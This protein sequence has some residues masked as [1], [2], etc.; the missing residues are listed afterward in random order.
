MDYITSLITSA[1]QSEFQKA[2]I[3][4]AKVLAAVVAKARKK[5]TP[6]IDILL[7][8]LPAEIEKINRE[9]TKTAQEQI[10]LA[11]SNCV[12][13][14]FTSDAA[15]PLIGWSDHA[16]IPDARLKSDSMMW[17]YWHKANSRQSPL[18]EATEFFDVLSERA[19]KLQT[20]LP[21]FVESLSKFTSLV[22]WGLPENAPQPKLI[23]KPIV[24]MSKE[25]VLDLI[26]ITKTMKSSGFNPEGQEQALQN[27]DTAA[28]KSGLTVD[29]VKHLA[30]SY[31]NLKDTIR[32]S[33]R[34]FAHEFEL[35]TG[36][37]ALHHGIFIGDEIVGSD[38]FVEVQNL[39]LDKKVCGIVTPSTLLNFLFRT[40]NNEK[41]GLIEFSYNNPLP[42][43]IVQE[44]ALACLGKWPYHLLYNNCEHFVT[45][46]L[47]NKASSETCENFLNS[48]NFI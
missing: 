29:R 38:L 27:V 48:L 11:V 28:E 42:L 30:D 10:K 34:H 8:V 32:G 2:T 4:S 17:S 44:R 35:P 40:A 25:D 1:L 37:T 21:K 5:N 3:N 47:Q 41:S 14:A 26:K 36:K 39:F 18:G 7:Q 6:S 33:P 24:R 45:W 31:Q 22:P 23:R 20:T 46:V 15:A 13:T 19:D 9:I 16:P 12:N 43:K